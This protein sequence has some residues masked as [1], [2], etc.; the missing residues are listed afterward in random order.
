MYY[1]INTNAIK[2]LRKPID[3]GWVQLNGVKDMDNI[4]TTDGFMEKSV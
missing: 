4:E 1:K 3:E 2:K